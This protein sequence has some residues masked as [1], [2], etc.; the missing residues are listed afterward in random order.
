MTSKPIKFEF[1][2]ILFD[3]DG[4]LI[5]STSCIERHWE[6]WAKDH[7]IDIDFVLQNAHGV[8]TIE[9][10]QI[11]AP[12]L[13]LKK[14]AAAFTHNEVN[15]TDGVLAI[16]GAHQILANLPEDK[17][18]IVTSGSYDLVKARLRATNLPIPSHL[19]TADDVR[20]GKPSP[21]PYL[22]G[23]KKFGLTSDQ[24]VVVED[25]P[26][27][28]RAGKAAGMKVIGILSTHTKTT[29]Q[30]AG[31]DFII[32]DLQHI[33]ITS[34]KNNQKLIIELDQTDH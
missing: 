9:T 29:L 25:S 31:A 27:G 13:D 11:V 32:N 19:V 22:I 2:A 1:S 28:V 16:K 4:V 17:W 6:E 3:L 30:E 7:N 14:E 34:N 5:D 8:R 26:I 15:D 12:H 33:Q 10:M 23:A 18:A 20:I 24:C 21:E